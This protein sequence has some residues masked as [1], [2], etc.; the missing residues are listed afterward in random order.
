M[1]Q[2]K[3]G[4]MVK[5]IRPKQRRTFNQFFVK[6]LPPLQSAI[7]FSHTF[8][9]KQAAGSAA[10]TNF[11]R[12]QLLHLWTF[13]ISTTVT[14]PILG[15]YRI[16]SITLYGTTIPD[17]ASVA[18]D[19][20]FDLI[21]SGTIGPN[22][23]YTVTTNSTGDTPCLKSYPPP[24]SSASQWTN[25]FAV[26]ASAA[27]TNFNEGAEV[28]FTVFSQTGCYLDL[29]LDCVGNDTPVTTSITT[30]GLTSGTPVL[31]S[32]DNIFLS[33]ASHGWDPAGVRQFTS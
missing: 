2:N 20:S 27:G 22:A 6:A 3:K 13:N 17:S 11:T 23:Q 19:N 15:A 25:V 4:K 8:R 30:S 9:F 29:K 32:L 31:N 18:V 33:G 5:K 1:P 24:G 12:G 28:L 26:N 7:R 21:W 14:Q 10:R 16:R